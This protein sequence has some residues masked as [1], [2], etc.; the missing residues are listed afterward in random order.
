MP[1]NCP[2]AP[3]SQREMHKD[4]GGGGGGVAMRARAARAPKP[5]TCATSCGTPPATHSATAASLACSSF[6]C[7]LGKAWVAMKYGA[8]HDEHLYASVLRATGGL[9]LPM[10]GSSAAHDNAEDHKQ[11]GSEFSAV[12]AATVRS[13]QHRGQSTQGLVSRSIR[14][15]SSLASRYLP[16]F[17]V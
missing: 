1:L 16:Y 5:K 9:V 15:I 3:P 12:P 8:C 13:P 10:R 14:P 4:G 7:R 6:T 2:V 11:A 17:G